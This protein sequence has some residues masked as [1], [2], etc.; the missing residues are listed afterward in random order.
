MSDST[1][2][3][4][5][6]RLVRFQLYLVYRLCH[7]F[8]ILGSLNKGQRDDRNESGQ[9]LGVTVFGITVAGP[10]KHGHRDLD[11]DHIVVLIRAMN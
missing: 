8:R 2:Y 3:L 1:L 4:R 9:A 5:G 6:M 11:A 10:C 7:G